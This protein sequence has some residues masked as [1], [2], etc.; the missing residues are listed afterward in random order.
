M[1][2]PIHM[3]L[4]IPATRTPQGALKF[5]ALI[6][7]ILSCNK[8]KKFHGLRSKLPQLFYFKVGILRAS[9][10]IFNSEVRICWND[11]SKFS[12][13]SS[14]QLTF[15]CGSSAKLKIS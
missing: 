10:K 1:V 4:K 12:S 7:K 6:I 11:A 15:C 2:H 13:I 14:S 8:K 9:H 3:P 5:V